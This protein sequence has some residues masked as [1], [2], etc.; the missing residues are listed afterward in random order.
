ML[1]SNDG[2]EHHMGQLAGSANP[3]LVIEAESSTRG[4]AS[5]TE[6]WKFTLSPERIEDRAFDVVVLEGD[7][8]LSPSFK[9]SKLE[10]Q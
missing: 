4:G 3:S 8:Q 10:S 5:L 7:I 6:L 9:E 1:Y 2:V